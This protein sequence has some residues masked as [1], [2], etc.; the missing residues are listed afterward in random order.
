ME[1]GSILEPGRPPKTDKAAILIDAVRMVTQLRGEAQK[2]QD[3]NSSL[4]ERIK[5]L[6]VRLPWGSFMVKIVRFFSMLFSIWKLLVSWKWLKKHQVYPFH[7]IKLYFL[8][9]RLKR[10]SFV[11]KSRGWR[12]RRKSW[13]SN[14]KPWMHNLASCLPHLPS[15]LHLL[16]PKVKLLGTSWF[17]SLV[18]L[19]LPCGSSCHLQRWILHRIMY[20]A[21]R[22]P[23]LATYNDL[24][25]HFKCIRFVIVLGCFSFYWSFLT[26]FLGWLS[27]FS[28][29]LKLVITCK[30]L[31][32]S[33]GNLCFTVL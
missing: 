25:L 27:L 19:E 10:M 9:F 15:L 32:S 13:S 28:Y 5:E 30:F 8:F 16:L 18:I 14:S 26:G 24:G 12:Q 23:K 21:L 33:S 29:D 2:L 11:M 4:Q 7:H 22:L 20:S 3:S 6:K 17:L 31:I 1:L